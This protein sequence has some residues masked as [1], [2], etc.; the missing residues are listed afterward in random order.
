MRGFARTDVQLAPDFSTAPEG[1][2]KG[3]CAGRGRVGTLSSMRSRLSPSVIGG[4]HMKLLSELAHDHF[5]PEPD[6]P[7]LGPFTRAFMHMMF[8]HVEFERRVAELADMITLTPGF[9]ETE[10]LGSARERPKK[11]TALCAKNHNKHPGGLP[12][13]DDIAKL[14]DEASRLCN[15]R[16]WLAHGVWWRIDTVAGIIGVHAVRVR[17]GEPPSREFTVD[18]IQQVAESFKDVEVELWKLQR[19]IEARLKPQPLPPKLSA[20]E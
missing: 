16:N 8:A 7:E 12:E 13:A 14:L 20:P 2:R 1:L 17:E 15:E 18:Q 5:L 6:S 10:L 19:T 9:G 11:F 3:R 4:R